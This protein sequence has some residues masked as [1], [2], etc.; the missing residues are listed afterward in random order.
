MEIDKTNIT[1]SDAIIRHPDNDNFISDHRNPSM[2]QNSSSS[3]SGVDNEFKTN[4]VAANIKNTPFSCFFLF[5]NYMIGSGILN[6]PYVFEQCGI[7]GAFI[8][9]IL[10][11]YFTWLGLMLIT[12]TAL[13]TSIFEY[14]QISHVA[15]GKFGDLLVDISVLFYSF[16]AELTYFIV[17]GYTASN[18]LVSWGCSSA[19]C[20]PYATIT[21]IMFL[22]IL[23][24]CMFRHFGHLHFLSIFSIMTIAIC[25]LLV[26]S[27]CRV[28]EGVYRCVC[29]VNN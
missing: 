23:P 17:V 22:I 10:A 7:V 4:D 9:Y 11:C 12:E 8:L 13:F 19:V 1:D 20:Q 27:A 21:I 2:I 5:L 15:Y 24:L 16:G 14:Q 28:S 6:Q 3:M 29:I 26:V 25:I 18:L